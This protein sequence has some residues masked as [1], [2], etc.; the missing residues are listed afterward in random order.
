M[1]VKTSLF[2]AGTT[3]VIYKHIYSEG[4]EKGLQGIQGK[5][6]GRETS[7]LL[8]TQSVT[9]NIPKASPRKGSLTLI[10]TRSTRKGNMQGSREVC[11][12]ER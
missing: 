6:Q 2:T 8:F 12:E 3:S 9:H 4:R 1:K 7:T 10:L 5:V 11:T